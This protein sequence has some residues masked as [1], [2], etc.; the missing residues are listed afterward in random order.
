M[1]RSGGFFRHYRRQSVRNEFRC[2][3]Q[4]FSVLG[5]KCQSQYQC[6]R[7]HFVHCSL[8]AFCCRAEVWSV[9]AEGI[10]CG[11]S[12]YRLSKGEGKALYL[13]SRGQGGTPYLGA[14]PT[15]TG[16]G[17]SLRLSR[18]SGRVDWLAAPFGRSCQSGFPAR[19]AL[20]GVRHPGG[21][22]HG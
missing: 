1:I 15:D 12:P 19:R 14:V 20:R 11:V 13:S 4:G 7:G 10:R 6:Q 2:M 8:F 17:N 22:Y 21:E 5:R 16:T 9:S 3:L 18:S